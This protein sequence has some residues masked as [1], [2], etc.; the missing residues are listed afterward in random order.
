VS[1][2]KRFDVIAPLT[3]CR[4]KHSNILERVCQENSVGENYVSTPQ[5][6]VK[7]GVFEQ[8]QACFVV[9]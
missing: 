6:L 4:K 9:L 7:H 5:L 1:I 3:F 2:E 8:I